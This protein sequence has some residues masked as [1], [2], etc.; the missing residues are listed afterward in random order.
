MGGNLN[1]LKPTYEQ[2]EQ[3]IKEFEEKIVA[4]VKKL[5][6]PYIKKP[7]KSRLKDRQTG[8]LDMI[9]SNLWD[10]HTF[11]ATRAFFPSPRPNL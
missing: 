4:N 2:L 1:G 11:P 10:I 3:K 7:D 8:Y 5:V 9:K 6:W